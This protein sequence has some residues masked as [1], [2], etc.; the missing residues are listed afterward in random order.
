MIKIYQW[1]ESLIINNKIIKTKCSYP[2]FAEEGTL[3]SLSTNVTWDNIEEV[4][5][6]YFSFGSLRQNKKGY[7]FDINGHTFKQR[8][9]KQLN[10]KYIL[11]F[12]DI[13]NS[14]SIKEIFSIHNNEMAIKYFKERGLN[15]CPMQK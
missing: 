12:K 5:Q 10:M 15:I 4:Y 8:K 6:N 2:F 1:K 14:M 7:C 13:T 11:K 3:E 9:V